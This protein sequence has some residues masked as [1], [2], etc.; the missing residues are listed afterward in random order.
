[1][2]TS[3]HL[4]YRRKIRL[5]STSKA[6]TPQSE[7]TNTG[8]QIII[9]TSAYKNGDL[10][11]LV[12]G[13]STFNPLPIPPNGWNLEVQSGGGN[14][15]F[16]YSKFANNEPSSYLVTGITP[17]N[18]CG[19]FLLVYRN[20]IVGQKV[21]T[22]SNLLFPS[23]K[24]SRN[25]SIFLGLAFYYLISSNLEQISAIGPLKMQIQHANVGNVPYIFSINMGAASLE[26][27]VVGEVYSGL[28]VKHPEGETDFT[29]TISIL[30]ELS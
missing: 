26:N 29:D 8:N 2:G 28:A 15:I 18:S 30:L 14:G 10:L 9:P 17:G 16:V 27:L 20:A 7:G 1:M 22:P 23:V 24:S 5:V 11:L 13:A 25:G 6:T 4:Y 3:S 21:G 19:G 12:V